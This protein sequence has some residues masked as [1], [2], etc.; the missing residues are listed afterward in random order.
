MRRLTALG[1]QI[2]PLN[3]AVSVHG[4]YADAVDCSHSTRPEAKTRVS[5]RINQ[6]RGYYIVTGVDGRRV[7]SEM[8]Y[9]APKRSGSIPCVAAKVAVSAVPAVYAFRNQ[10][11]L[12]MP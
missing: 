8:F 4:T 5:G 6:Y 7:Q 3:R 11:L 12:Y 1:V 9:L 10:F 2:L